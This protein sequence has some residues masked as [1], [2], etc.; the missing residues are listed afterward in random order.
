MREKRLKRKYEL[1][2]LKLTISEEARQRAF[3]SLHLEIMEYLNEYDVP[4]FLR[5]QSEEPDISGRFLSVSDRDIQEASNKIKH[6]LDTPKDFEENREFLYPRIEV[7]VEDE[8]IPLWEDYM[9]IMTLCHEAG[10][11]ESYRTGVRD[12]HD[13][14]EEEQFADDFIKV[15]VRKLGNLRDKLALQMFISVRLDREE[16]LEIDNYLRFLGVS[17]EDIHKFKQEE[18]NAN[19]R[20]WKDRLFGVDKRKNGTRERRYQHGR[21]FGN[22][23]AVG[24]C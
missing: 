3:K 4:V 2:I 20:N 16:L 14:E 6:L 24:N 23:V 8:T 22:N 9:R 11:F 13:Y 10:H 1:S 7:F 18:K 19:R 17:W 5:S 15:F 12:E 21:N